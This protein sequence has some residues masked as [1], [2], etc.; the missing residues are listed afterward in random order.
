[1]GRDLDPLPP[2]AATFRDELGR[3]WGRNSFFLFLSFFSSKIRT[4]ETEEEKECGDSGLILSFVL[5]LFFS[6][7]FVLILLNNLFRE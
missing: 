5:C 6:Q 1:M 2:V 7:S 4:R 3:N